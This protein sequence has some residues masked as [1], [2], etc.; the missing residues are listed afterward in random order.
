MTSSIPAPQLKVV[1]TDNHSTELGNQFRE[2]RSCFQL[3]AH[4]YGYPERSQQLLELELAILANSERIAEALNQDFNGRSTAESYL[5]EIFGVIDDIRHTR[6]HLKA[7]MKP[8]KCQTNLL[9]WPGRSRIRHSPLGVIAI[10]GAFNYPFLLTISPLVAAIAAGNHAMV[11][12]SE[13]TPKTAAIIEE[14]L[15]GIFS[16]DKVFVVN[17]DRL[18]AQAMS[19]LPFDHIFFTGSQHVGKQILTA[20]APNLTPVTLE[21]GGKSPAIIGPT[22]DIDKAVESICYTKF[23]NAG[24]TCVA[25]DY[26]LLPESQ[27]DEFIAK[28]TNCIEQLYPN[29]ASNE[30]Y[31]NLISE[32]EQQRLANW[33]DEAKALGAEVRAVGVT[34]NNAK[35]KQR[36]APTL[37]W[38]CPVNCQLLNQEIFGPVLPIV[39]YQDFASAIVWVQRRPKP[40]A[41][42]IFE[43]CNATIEHVLS[44][45]QSGGVTVNG[46]VYHVGQHSLPFGGVGGSGMGRYHGFFGF[47]TFSHKRAVFAVSR[48]TNDKAL[49]PPY[50]DKFSWLVGT[51]LR[52]KPYRLKLHKQAS[53]PGNQDIMKQTYISPLESLVAWESSKPNTIWLTQPLADGTIKTYT[54]S[55]AADAARRLANYLTSLDL[56]PGSNIVILGNNN[57]EWLLADLAIWM[58]GHVSVPLYATIGPDTFSYVLEHCN[59]QAMMVGK[60]DGIADRW[61]EIKDVIPDKLKKIRLPQSPEFEAADWEWINRN[62]SPQ[63]QFV[64]REATDLAT[65][66]YTS[67]TTG[68]PK[69][70]MHS[71]HSLISPSEITRD[72]WHPSE[73]DRMLSYLPLA[74]VAERVVVEIP[75]LIFGFQIFFNHS[76]ETFPADLLRAKPTRFFS[77]P[78]LWTKFYQAVNAKV[79]QWKQKLLFNIPVVGKKVKQKILIQLGLQN[80]RLGFT[81]A[82]PLSGEII[83]WY[84]S[85]GLELLEVYGMTENAATSHASAIGQTKPGYVGIPLPGVDC[86]IDDNGEILVKSPGQM[87][88][89]Y[90]Q[91]ELT[92]EKM[93]KDGYFKTGDRGTLDS[94]GRLKITGRVNDL[95][96]TSKGKFIAPVPIENRLGSYPGLETV[97]VSG[98]GAPQPYGLVT[99]SPDSKVSRDKNNTFCSGLRQYLS[100]VNSELEDHEKLAFLV[101]CK[102]PWTIESGLLTPTMKLKRDMI[103]QHYDKYVDQW[104]KSGEVVIFE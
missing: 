70:V 101:I 22:S 35:N 72:T 38:H 48:W 65:I 84:R 67:G 47:E 76:L 74:H 3:N 5:L 77:V 81:A 26:V 52:K 18:I 97:C 87:L 12:P 7:W 20:A 39:T 9:F 4:H 73:N 90:R 75:A 49:R 15:A 2:M 46:C 57:A 95:F 79:P 82:A 86:V 23:L 53:V 41:L 45:T 92:E 10:F 78:R 85:L 60:L 34:P 19:A 100:E 104:S 102:Q 58:S 66:I 68:K 89:Y 17:G 1:N 50:T 25:P 98:R 28:A 11:K 40:L 69:G 29:L 24:Q 30:D 56:K 80:A 83:R 88:G 31:S 44:C 64:N 91:P 51:L 94:Q 16:R 96:K 37:V 61:N 71:F 21:L 42:Y 63:K 99:L 93:T 103:E 14:I 32:Q 27:L 59:A 36:M 55:Q 6:K 33:I 62:Y 8:V 54:W 13:L 43:T